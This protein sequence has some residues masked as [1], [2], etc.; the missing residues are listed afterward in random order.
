MKGNIFYV[1][2]GMIILLSIFLL[3]YNILRIFCVWD[4]LFKIF[5]GVFI[6][7]V[8]MSLCFFGVRIVLVRDLN[9]IYIFGGYIFFDRFL[10]VFRLRI[11]F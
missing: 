11:I 1:K 8:V 3:L 5:L 2:I 6:F 7:R 10:S 9:G 4:E